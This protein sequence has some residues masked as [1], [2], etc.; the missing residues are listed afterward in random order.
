MLT[1]LVYLT[2]DG[3]G[4]DVIRDESVGMFVLEVGKVSDWRVLIIFL[5]VGRDEGVS[6]SFPYCLV[7]A[8][9]LTQVDLSL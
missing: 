5:G 3:I 4:L 8:C 9:L 1:D 2:I 6:S 7:I